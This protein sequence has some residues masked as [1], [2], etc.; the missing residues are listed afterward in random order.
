MDAAAQLAEA[1]G[2]I[3]DLMAMANRYEAVS[4]YG[5]VAW[6]HREAGWWTARADTARRALAAA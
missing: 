6:A 2:H 3:A 1:E 5:L 4:D